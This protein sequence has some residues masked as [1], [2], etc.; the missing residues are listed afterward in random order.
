C[1]RK[2]LSVV[3]IAAAIVVAVG[4]VATAVELRSHSA[5]LKGSSQ[6]AVITPTFT[7]Q[8]EVTPPVRSTQCTTPVTF[9]FTGTITATAKGTV[10]YRWLYSSGKQGPVQN[11][12]FAVAGDKQVTGD[13]VSTKTAGVGWGE[14]QLVNPGGKVSDKASYKLLCTSAA[15]GYSAVAS[16]QPPTFNA[17]A[18]AATPPAFTASGS[19]TSPKAAKVTYYWALSN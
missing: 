14:I 4:V 16:V 5:N 11:L 12:A 3:T 9:A 8:P 2:V 1:K 17:G 18:C 15:A 10:S 13:T 6:V 7:A 19:I